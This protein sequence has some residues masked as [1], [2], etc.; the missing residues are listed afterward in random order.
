MSVFFI[1]ASVILA[2]LAAAMVGV[3]VVVAIDD[4]ACRDHT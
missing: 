3:T 1:V 2:L 4:A